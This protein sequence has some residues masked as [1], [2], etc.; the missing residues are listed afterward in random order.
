MKTMICLLLDRSGSMAGRERDVVGGV[1]RFI[2]EQQG[3]EGDASLAIVHFD[4]RGIERFR[5]M[6]PIASVF[7]LERG[8]Y[9]P[10]GNT[11]LLEAVTKTI[12]QLDEDWRR[13]QPDRAI[14]VIVTDGE[15]NSSPKEYTKGRV[16][17][18][19]DARQ[20]SGYWSFVYLGANVDAFKESGS[21]GIWATNAASYTPSERGMSSMFAASSATV[22]NVRMTGSTV[23]CN[24]GGDIGED[25]MVRVTGTFGAK[26]GPDV[27]TPV[28]GAPF[29][30]TG[31]WAPPDG[32]KASWVPPPT[33][34]TTTPGPAWVPPTITT[35]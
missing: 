21:M 13:E 7:P 4:S 3:V 25:G 28:M 17:E 6:I 8:E 10:F 29:T 35:T 23:A 26:P 9:R 14:M 2:A 11:P 12:A 22:T 34:Q 16:R 24:L 1:N 33:A 27:S 15:E 5:P 20:R 31:T 19:I 30:T 18:L 32:S